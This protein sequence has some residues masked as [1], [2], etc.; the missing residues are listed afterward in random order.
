MKLYKDRKRKQISKKS[1]MP[2]IKLNFCCATIGFA[3]PIVYERNSL[4]SFTLVE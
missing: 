4:Y 3:G 1:I 2:R